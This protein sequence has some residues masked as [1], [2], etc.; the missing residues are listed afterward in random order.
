MSPNLHFDHVLI[1][2]MIIPAVNAFKRCR[3]PNSK[4]HYPGWRYLLRVAI[5]CIFLATTMDAAAGT[6]DVQIHEINGKTMGTFYHVKISHP[7]K[8][9]RVILK[10]KIDTRLQAVND[11]MSMYLKTSEISRFNRSPKNTPMVIS[12]GFVLVL[13]Q[14]RTL[15]DLT[16]G[17]WD[18]TIKS[19]VDLWGFGTTRANGKMPDKSAINHALEN[20]GFDKIVLFENTLAKKSPNITLDMGSIAKGYGVDQVAALL[21]ENQFKNTLVEIGGEVVGSG[22]KRPGK[23]WNVGIATPDKQVA[24]Q[25]V[26]Q[27]IALQNQALATS[28]DYRNFVVLNKHAYSHIIDPSTGY[29]VK[30]G[31]VSASVL[32]DTCTLAD[33]LATALMVMGPQKGIAL[34]NRMAKTECFIIVQE[35]DGTFSDRYSNGFPGKTQ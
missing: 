8:I 7:G 18:G 21:L 25:T 35:A 32:A 22:E 5:V 20:T 28:G 14:A 3:H 27:A 31:V 16:G 34:V 19:L 10:N 13:K 29:P 15:Y 11:S 12:D 4:E 26:Y 24:R 1:F 2:A 17:A 23:T 9:D 30:N 6:H 33:G